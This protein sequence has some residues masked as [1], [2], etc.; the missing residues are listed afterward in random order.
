MGHLGYIYTL[1]PSLQRMARQVLRVFIILVFI[2]AVAKAL[3]VCKGGD[4]K[5]F[6]N[7]SINLDESRL[8]LYHGVNPVGV[9]T[10][11]APLDEDKH[12]KHITRD[13]NFEIWL[14]NV[15]AN[16][17]GLYSLLYSKRTNGSR[18]EQM[19]G[20]LDIVIPPPTQCRPVV[21]LI[22]EGEIYY[23]NATWPERDC[24]TPQDALI[25]NSSW[26]NTSML[27]VNSTENPGLYIVCMRGPAVDCAKDPSMYCSQIYIN[28]KSERKIKKAEIIHT[29]NNIQ[30][31]QHM[32]FQ[33]NKM[34]TSNYK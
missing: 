34:D 4:V 22:K 25:W 31:C 3:D 30:E 18:R 23:L 14:H 6:S 32:M 19:N 1:I 15:S 10:R 13:E 26:Q 16:D 29:W 11:D 28:R 21:N 27:R 8:T 20:S 5:L 33:K 12:E 17:Q 9:W 2:I 24:G 7:T